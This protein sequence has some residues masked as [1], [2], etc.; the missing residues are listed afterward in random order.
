MFPAKMADVDGNY[1]NELSRTCHVIRLLRL[2]ILLPALDKKI[3]RIT[4]FEGKNYNFMVIIFINKNICFRVIMEVLYKTL[5]FLK[6]QIFK[7]NT[8]G[9]RKHNA[10]TGRALKMKYGGDLQVRK[11]RNRTLKR[12]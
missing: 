1:A 9:G 4:S 11:F 10:L 6:M 12:E 5:F 7:Q 8:E 2:A 3:I